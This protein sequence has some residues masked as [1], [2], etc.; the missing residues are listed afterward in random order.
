MAKKAHRSTQLAMQEAEKK[1]QYGYQPGAGVS[2]PGTASAKDA[3]KDRS[4]AEKALAK[5]GQSILP[6]SNIITTLGF[7]I[8]ALGMM[9][10][11]NAVAFAAAHPALVGVT[12]E[13]LPKKGQPQDY[14]VWMA[15]FTGPDA[16]DHK[17]AFGIGLLLACSVDVSDKRTGMVEETADENAANK[18]DLE[19]EAIG[20]FEEG[21]T[22]DANDT[23]GFVT[24]LHASK[25]ATGKVSY[26]ELRKR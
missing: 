1:A 22:D 15:A 17:R 23:I 14:T 20:L 12:Y 2:I 26:K 24:K 19:E 7:V 25:R 16:D 18:V 3:W 6:S 4:G 13:T 9:C 10:V 21:K 5:S 11:F 8:Q